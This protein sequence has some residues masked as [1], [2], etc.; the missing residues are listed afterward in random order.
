MLLSCTTGIA[1]CLPVREIIIHRLPPA[2]A[3]ALLLEQ[4]RILMKT[5][6]FV[7]SN[8]PVSL[9]FKGPTKKESDEAGE[10][11]SDGPCPDFTKYLYF[12]FAPTLVYRNRYPRSALSV[13]LFLPRLRT[14]MLCYVVCWPCR[15]NSIRW[16]WVSWNFVQVIGVLFYL[17]FIFVRFCVPVRPS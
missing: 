17:Y 4:V 6:A 12:S 3:V 11:G 10:D 13:Y 14:I 1:I 5:H 9:A 15:T 16:R 2:S 7:R 8:I